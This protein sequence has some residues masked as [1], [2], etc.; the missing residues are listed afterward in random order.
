LGRR[1]FGV[2]GQLL[3][4]APCPV[5]AVPAGAAAVRDR[6]EWRPAA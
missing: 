1:M 3:G 6:D 2:I 5:V 4:E